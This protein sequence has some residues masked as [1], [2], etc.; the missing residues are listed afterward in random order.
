MSSGTVLVTGA[1]GFVGGQ[2]ARTLAERGCRVRALYRRAAPPPGLLGLAERGVELV[3]GDLEEPQT[4]RRV[5]QGVE[6][7]VHAGGPAQYW[8]PEELFRRGI[9]EVTLR[10]LEESRRAGCRV[11]VYV[12]S[13]SVHGFGPH[14]GSS[15]EGPYYPLMTPY[16]RY[17]R[18]AER[19][20]V[21]GAEAPLRT[22]VLRP[23][24]V[25][26]PGD[27]TTFYR[28]LHYQR[29]GVKGVV[30]RGE[31]LTSLVY[32][33]DLAEAILRALE[34]EGVSGE[35]FNVTGGEEVTWR[36]ALDYTASLLGVRPWLNLPVPVARFLVTAVL[37]PVFALAPL[38]VGQYL[39]RYAIEHVV[40]DFHF[41]IEKARRLLGYE[42]RVSWREGLRRTVEAYLEHEPGG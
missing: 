7:V 12:S 39:T 29:K 41:S 10:L 31:H 33:E 8:G 25:Y 19:A 35:I 24:D 30:G 2:A 21:A 16:Q 4:V 28:L 42:P 15:E 9:L 38:P 23:G 6:R 34:K 37:T 40:H 26:G 17:K 20:V 32:V 22:L 5:V 11:F 3:R 27:L 13:L 36:E 1:S 14:R 18:E